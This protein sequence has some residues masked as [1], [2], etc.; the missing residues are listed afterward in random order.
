MTFYF[1]PSRC[2]T[3]QNISREMSILYRRTLWSLCGQIVFYTVM[4]NYYSKPNTAVNN[5]K[6]RFGYEQI[7]LAYTKYIAKTDIIYPIYYHYKPNSVKKKE[8]LSINIYTHT[9][10]YVGFVQARILGGG[11]WLVIWPPL[12]MICENIFCLYIYYN[13]L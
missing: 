4:L 5:R 9:H 8:S 3:K 6:C 13:L 2:T 10:T 7:S 11:G 12:E 1:L